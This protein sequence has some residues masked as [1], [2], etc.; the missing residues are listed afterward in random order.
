MIIYYSY[1]GSLA[2]INYKEAQLK[3]RKTLNSLKW[4]FLRFE[5]GICLMKITIQNH[6]S[7]LIF[8]NYLGDY[9]MF[10]EY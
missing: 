5:L 7:T 1:Y 8:K 10:I 6:Q 2:L 3:K 4:N 9:S